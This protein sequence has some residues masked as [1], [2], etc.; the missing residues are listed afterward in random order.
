MSDPAREIGEIARLREQPAGDAAEL[1]LRARCGRK[2]AEHQH[3]HVRFAGEQACRIGVHRRGGE[4]FDELAS[5]IA[6]AVAA[7]SSRLKAM[8]PPNAGCRV[9]ALGGF[10]RA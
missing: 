2:L 5:L 8:M 3:A 6:A 10:V 4:H 1:E 9:G 7:S